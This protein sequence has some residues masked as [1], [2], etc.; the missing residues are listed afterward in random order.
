MEGRDREEAERGGWDGCPARRGAGEVAHGGWDGC[1][2]R[3]GAG[4]VA[5]GGT[6]ARWWKD[7]GQP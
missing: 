2:A 6:K 3:R 7:V 5:H 4:E 1:P